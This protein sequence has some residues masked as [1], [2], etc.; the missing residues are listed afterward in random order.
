MAQHCCNTVHA[1][2]RLN[3]EE[4]WWPKI[5][6]CLI[7]GESPGNPGSLHFYDPI[8]VGRPDPVSIRHHLLNELVAV[9]L[10]Q[11]AT[12]E[13]FTERGYFFDHA[14]RCQIPMKNVK[15]DRQR[16]KKYQSEL[17]GKQ[18]HLARLIESFD[19]VWVMGHMAGNAVA[20][21][22]LITADTRSLIPAYTEG[23]RF[24]IS[25]YVRQYPS[26]KPHDILAA[27]VAF[28]GG[29]LD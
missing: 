20:N 10:L 17:V 28:L 29:T 12:R 14:V 21:L 7:I 9:G 24:F 3:V 2:D 16:A 15:H 1:A 13:D 5:P 6:R 19:V 11:V 27:F 8:P 22:G 18:N 4:T 26:Y 25:P 23:R